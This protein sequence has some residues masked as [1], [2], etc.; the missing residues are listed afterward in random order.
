MEALFCRVFIQRLE[1]QAICLRFLDTIVVVN[2]NCLFLLSLGNI[3]KFVHTIFFY[4]FLPNE[5]LNATAKL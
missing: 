1:Q 5:K 3:R 2:N 4:L